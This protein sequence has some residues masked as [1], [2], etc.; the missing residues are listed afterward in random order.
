M[1]CVPSR[2]KY[3]SKKTEYNGV[4]YDSVKEVR[5]AQQLDLLIKAKE[6]K[7]YERQIVIPLEV[8]G[9]KI[10]KYI[11]DFKLIYPDGR[12]ELVEIKSAYTAK[13]PL[14]RL[15]RKLFE[16]TY[17]QAHPDVSYRVVEL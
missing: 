1:W 4:M 8:N 14:Y 10:C 6:L 7:S 12:E 13:L 17:L 16:A 9:S 11:C 15:K 5:Y 2:S 3:G